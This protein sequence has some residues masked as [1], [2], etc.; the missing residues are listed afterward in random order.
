MA[1][2]ANWRPAE[3][4]HPRSPDGRRSAQRNHCDG[5]LAVSGARPRGA[6]TGFRNWSRNQPPRQCRDRD[7]LDRTARLSDALLALVNPGLLAKLHRVERHL[8]GNRVHANVL[9]EKRVIYDGLFANAKK[10]K[11]FADG[12]DS[13]TNQ[14]MVDR[15]PR[16]GTSF[17]GSA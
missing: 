4:A 8:Q 1:A 10:K 6:T 14:E 9:K 12:R 15:F 5:T 17:S 13:L 11:Q 7:P 16:N 3:H 2:P